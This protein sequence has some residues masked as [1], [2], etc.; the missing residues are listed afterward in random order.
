MEHNQPSHHHSGHQHGSLIQTL[1]DCAAACERC[2]AACL[3]ESDVK[4]MTHCI[5]LDRDCADICTLA[6]RLLMRDSEIAHDFLLVCEKICRL[7]AE[8]CSL[9]QHEHCK[10]CAAECR[11]CEV[12]CHQH[13][14]QAN[15]SEAAGSQ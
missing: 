8:E 15:L 14:G 12:A 10:R 7:C 5:E 9:H 13:H 1:L 3:D 6:A 4:Y 11:A 2:A